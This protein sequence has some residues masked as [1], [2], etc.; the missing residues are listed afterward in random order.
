MVLAGHS[1]I[2]AVLR[3]ATGRAVAGSPPLVGLAN[4]IARRTNQATLRVITQIA[5]IGYRRRRRRQVHIIRP[6]RRI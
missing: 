5:L 1:F 6:Y 3:V 4:K 2:M